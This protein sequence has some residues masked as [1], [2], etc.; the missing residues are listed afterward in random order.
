[1]KI[2]VLDKL[3]L[4]LD[5]PFEILDEI[6]EVAFYDATSQEE[7][8]DHV[9]DSDVI[10][11]NK[12]KITESVIDKCKNL[13]LICVFATGFDNIDVVA[14]RKYGVA[15]CN[16]PGYST[17]SVALYTIATVLSL[18]TNLKEYNDYVRC[19]DY[20][21]SGIPNKIAPVFHELT[22]KTWGIV[23][24]GNIG[25]AV[26][27]IAEVLGAR[28]IVNKRT[29]SAEFNCVDIDTLCKE[30]DIITVHCPLNDSTRGMINK[31]RINLMKKDVVLV[32]EAR[33]AVLNEAD[34][35]DAVISGRIGAFGCDV[36]SSEPFLRD[37]P[38]YK[39]KDKSN[40]L[41]TPHAAWAAYEARERCLKII[42]ENIRSFLNGEKHNRVDLL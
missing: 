39:I 24:C 4:G 26:L 15:V 27:R 16:V 22:G 32:N 18:V 23:G 42:L 31:E 2:T 12:V 17:D 33:G 13:K 35:A 38:Y 40:V 3:S 9:G 10:L 37:H 6:G 14:A 5:L 20:S 11:I 8:V 28:V 36:Y 7:T 30:S 29:P 19:G 25:K 21:A 41:L 34:V 1:M